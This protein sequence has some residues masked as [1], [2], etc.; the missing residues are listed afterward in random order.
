[1]RLSRNLSCGRGARTRNTHVTKRS[2]WVKSLLSLAAIGGAT[3]G[4]ANAQAI[5]ADFHGWED[6]ILSP[7]WSVRSFALFR[8]SQFPK[9][10]SPTGRDRMVQ[11]L[12]QE[13]DGTIAPPSSSDAQGEEGFG[14]YLGTLT[15]LVALFNDPRAT[16]YFARFGVAFSNGARFQVAAAGD[17]G[18]DALVETWNRAPA[19]RPGV[20]QTAGLALGFADSTGASLTPVHRAQIRALILEAATDPAARVRMA[21][22]DAATATGDPTYVGLLQYLSA[23]DSAA[24]GGGRYVARAATGAAALLS[25]KAGTTA[26]AALAGALAEQVDAACTAQWVSPVGA[27]QSLIAKANAAAASIRAGRLDAARGELGAFRAELTAQR[28]LHVSQLAFAILDGAAA[29]LLVRI[30]A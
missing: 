16:P 1:M 13:A 3:A 20:V 26:P 21:F 28:G 25:G 9:A 4:T 29:R 24:L 12:Q 15:D 11:L 18:I 14:E 5:P 10:I 6:S 23:D 2:V 7:T 22:V 30:H 17:A 19:F 27:C 8:L